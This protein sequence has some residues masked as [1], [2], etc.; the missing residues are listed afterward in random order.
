M[1]TI[2]ERIAY[3]EERIKFWEGHK[4]QQVWIG[5]KS[6]LEEVLRECQLM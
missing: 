3:A 4:E 1:K 2:E 5:I 6:E